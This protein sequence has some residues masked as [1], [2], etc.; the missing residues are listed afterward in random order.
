MDDENAMAAGANPDQRLMGRVALCPLTADPPTLA[1][2]D[3]VAR[4]L[5]I[6]DRVIWALGTNPRKQPQFS[7]AQRLEMLNAIVAE[8]GWQ[9]RVMPMLYTGSTVRFALSHRAVAIVRGLR[10]PDDFANE[11]PQA[12]ANRGIG[13]GVETLFLAAAPIYAV[14]SSS[15]VR[16]LLLLGESVD[17]YVPPAV[18]DWL[19]SRAK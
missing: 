15:L 2:Q 17:A 9:G 11:F 1:H 10:S 14:C 12:V 7:Q 5:G 19:S 8:Q 16:E 6:F 3:I 18:C 4:A 13:E